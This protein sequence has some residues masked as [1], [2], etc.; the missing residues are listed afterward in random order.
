MYLNKFIYLNKLCDYVLVQH[1]ET[2]KLVCIYRDIYKYVI[3]AD[4]YKSYKYAE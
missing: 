2:D 4:I 1:D 3:H